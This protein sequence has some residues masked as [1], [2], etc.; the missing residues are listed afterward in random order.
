MQKVLECRTS[1]WRTG[2]TYRWPAAVPATQPPEPRQRPPHSVAWYRPHSPPRQVIGFD[3]GG[4]S[5]DVSRY[6][7]TYEHVFE[8][9]TAGVTIQVRCVCVCGGGG[10]HPGAVGAAGKAPATTRTTGTPLCPRCRGH[11]TGAMRGVGG[12]KRSTL[13]PNVGSPTRHYTLLLARFHTPPGSPAGHQHGSCGGRQPLS[14]PQRSLRSGPRVRGRAPRA[15]G[16][17]KGRPAG[18]HGRKPAAGPHPARVLP[19]GARC[20]DEVGEECCSVL[21]LIPYGVP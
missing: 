16:L 21:P 19:Q 12:A 4:T 10:H 17:Q 6:A 20:A 14:V 7:G 1:A 3:M 2:A 5:T 13:A 9:T 8:T 15:S 11:R 18:H